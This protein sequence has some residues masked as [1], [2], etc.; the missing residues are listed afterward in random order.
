[1]IERLMDAA[2][3]ARLGIDP[4][5]AAPAQH[6][7][8][9][10]DALHEPDGPDLRQR[11]LRV[12]HGPGPGARRLERLRRA[13]GRS[14]ERAA[15]CAAAAS[16]PSSSGPAATCSR[17]ASRSTS[18]ADGYIEIYSAT[19]AMGQGIATSYAQLAVD[20][21][22]V[23]IEKIRIVQGDTDRGTGFGSAG[24][25]SLFTGGSAVQVASRKTVDK[26]Q[27]LAADALEAAPRRH[28]VRRRA[29]PHRRHRPRASSCS[30]WPGASRDRQVFVDS[31]SIGRR[32]DLAQ[33]LPRLRGRG[34]PRHRRGRGGSYASVNDVGRVVNPTIVRGQLD[35]GAVQGLGQ[36]LC[37]QMVYDRE[38]GPAADR[39]AS[40]TTRCR[41]P[42]WCAASAPR[43]TSRCPA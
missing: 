9:R 38:I 31:T 3:R 35:G 40:W 26:A 5:R 2:A 41:A 8:A 29:L 10:A 24:S 11:Q 37:E 15:G 6:D 30:S 28:R 32:P 39:H 16:P 22:D 43:W 13:R 17:S 20:V 21:F 23:P 19:Q 33:R 36:A 14:R 27:D 18:P 7:P 34:R 25:R 42:T 4:R 12:D 1:M